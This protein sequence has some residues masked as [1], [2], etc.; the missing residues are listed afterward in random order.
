MKRVGPATAVKMLFAMARVQVKMTFVLV[1]VYAWVLTRVNV[2]DHGKAKLAIFQFA[3]ILLPTKIQHAMAMVRAQVPTLADA[4][5]LIWV[6]NANLPFALASPLPINHH[7][8]VMDCAFR[9]IRVPANLDGREIVVT[10]THALVFRIPI[11]QVFALAE[12]FAPLLIL[13]SAIHNLVAHFVI[14]PCVMACQQAIPV[15]VPVQALAYRTI[16][17]F[18]RR[19]SLVTRVN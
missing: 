3:S 15:F 14:S 4:L 18:A 11:V 5:A 9:Q 8:A 2:K 6:P 17:V 16:L 7:A 12:V 19:A 1:T 13:A 10:F